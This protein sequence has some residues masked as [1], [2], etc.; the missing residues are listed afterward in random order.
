MLSLVT[1][2]AGPGFEAPGTGD[3]NLPAIVGGV[4]KPMVLVGLSV[5]IVFGFF[6]LTGRKA[7][8]VPSR[9]QF[10]GEGVY[11]FVRDGIAQDAIGPEF[12]KFVPYLTA[13][14]SFV[15]V[16]NIFGIIPVIQFPS[17]AR[18][19]FPAG[20][21]LV[22]WLVFNY[23]GIKRKGFGKYLKEVVYPPG[24]PTWILPLLIPLEFIQTILTRPLTLGLRLFANMFAGHLMLLVFILGGEYMLVHGSGA[25]PFLS[26]FAFLMGI[27]MTIFEALIQVLQAYIF[28]LLTALY[29]AGALADEH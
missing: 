17:M 21:A 3:F 6:M 4:T 28:V 25:L 13:L 22:S 9:G 24:V 15:L 27:A 23:V 29:I 10:L 7:L 16:N 2:A 1:L 8:V 20:L 26:P 18:I 19:G 5:V 14:F 11:R 12:I